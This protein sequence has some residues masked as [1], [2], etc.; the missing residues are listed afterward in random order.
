MAEQGVASVANDCT[1]AGRYSA[2]LT[3]SGDGVLS[4]GDLIAIEYAACFG[5][6]PTT[7]FNTSAELAID[8]IESTASGEFQL[9]GNYRTVGQA[10]SDVEIA[11]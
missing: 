7:A 5:D 11:P 6:L 8:L 10:N 2:N 1:G 4:S 9:S 3:D